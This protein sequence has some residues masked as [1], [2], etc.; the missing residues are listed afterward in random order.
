M[1]ARIDYTV[2][3]VLTV[4]YD[5]FVGAISPDTVIPARLDDL[6]GIP[7]DAAVGVNDFLKRTNTVKFS[8]AAI[9]GTAR[10]IAA[11]AHAEGFDAH[12]RSVLIRLEEKR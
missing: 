10:S 2:P 5:N 3:P 8:A 7:P 11:L 4:S 9:E 6:T 12:A 1:G